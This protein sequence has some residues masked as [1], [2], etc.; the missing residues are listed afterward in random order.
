[1]SLRG[2]NTASAPGSC[3]GRFLCEQPD[4]V[5]NFK[6]DWQANRS[7]TE[8]Y[9]RM[10]TALRRKMSGA[11]KREREEWR[12]GDDSP[13]AGA[14]S[15]TSAVG[16]E[17]PRTKV[18][19]VQDAY[20]PASPISPTVAAG[21]FPRSTRH[22]APEAVSIKPPPTTEDPINST[23][24]GAGNVNATMD[25]AMALDAIKRRLEHTT[26]P[27][28]QAT[29]LLQLSSVAM[30]PGATTNAVIDFLFSFLQQHQQSGG[31]NPSAS[32]GNE[33][34]THATPASS[35][36]GT[37]P[38][39][40]GAIV[41]GL[42][43]LLAVKAKVVEPMIHV[44]DMAEQLVQCMS[45]AE[46]FKLRH[47]MLR[48]VVDCRMI[49]K[50]YDQLEL[51][52]RACVHHGDAGM[53]AICLRGYL[54]LHD[55]GYR[56]S[57]A[58]S[59]KLFDLLS[60]FLLHGNDDDHVRVVA[61]R[62]LAALSQVHPELLEV[63]SKYFP[64]SSSL[65]FR[66]KVFYVLCMSANDISAVVRKEIAICM[67]SFD[68]GNGGGGS[69]DAVV[70]HALQKAQISEE[71]TDTEMKSVQMLSSGAL[72][73]LLEDKSV[74]YSF[75]GFCRGLDVV[76]GCHGS[77]QEY[78]IPADEVR[79]EMERT[80]P[81]SRDRDARG[82]AAACLLTQRK[83]CYHEEFSLTSEEV[84]FIMSDEN[85]Q[86]DASAMA[87]IL[88]CL[89]LC[90]TSSVWMVQRIVEY[91]LHG[92]AHI[93]SDNE[94]EIERFIQVVE[95][96]QQ[97]CG[98]AIRMDVSLMDT[99]REAET[100]K[101][102]VVGSATVRVCA[103]L[104]NQQNASPSVQEDGGGSR[105]ITALFKLA[106]KETPRQRHSGSAAN[107]IE[108]S[109]YA[110]LQQCQPSSKTF[111]ANLKTVLVLYLFIQCLRSAAGVKSEASGL[112]ILE[113]VLQL[114]QHVWNA[115]PET[116]ST[117]PT[118]SYVSMDAMLGHSDGANRDDSKAPSDAYSRPHLS[119]PLTRGCQEL[120]DLASELYIKEQ[121][122]SVK[123]R[124]DL[125]QT[126]LLARGG[127][128][129]AH[130]QRHP[131]DVDEVS[132]H[133]RWLSSE[134][135]KLRF[136]FT[137]QHVM[138]EEWFSDQLNN[139]VTSLD[140]FKHLPSRCVS[141][142]IYEP[143]QDSKE[144]EIIAQWP[145]DVRIRG[146]LE[147]VSDL[148]QIYVKVQNSV[149]PYDRIGIDPC[150]LPNGETK[151]HHVPL[152]TIGFQTAAKYLVD[153][154]ISLTVPPFSDPTSFSISLCIQHPELPGATE[155]KQQPD[156]SKCATEA[157]V[158]PSFTEISEP[159]KSRIF[160]RT[161]ATIRPTTMRAS[162]TA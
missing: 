123:P 37:E 73:D 94:Q 126:I 121:G 15:I 47:D 107:G 2:L 66:E 141:A 30:S 44:D 21:I 63:P 134:A 35:G 150:V 49:S 91:V 103:A 10:G 115:F 6:D 124:A 146:K 57:T 112:R 40:L 83:A 48:I 60:T 140:A 98:G 8:D 80:R 28:L 159:V 85:A 158:S 61:V 18:T 92:A 144:R 16:A 26:E 135:V 23:A 128:V 22:Q 96:I 24:L 102:V 116:E 100:H 118:S 13:T 65:S 139:S 72:L 113:L 19:R 160:H 101:S 76:P 43:N 27:H 117:R 161:I 138:P 56:L 129:L 59:V 69:F 133:L 79:L 53:Q 81:G 84:N 89:L 88:S 14:L 147:N 50:K 3:N 97:K 1:M 12:A 55:A 155:M 82:P 68:A 17:G 153:H 157:V 109:W 122:W 111:T 78:R 58:S 62:L 70:E 86:T 156:G 137:D 71:L 110:D 148:T 20:I 162:A 90:E 105:S 136:L 5:I 114:K 4:G 143:S 9:P 45:V 106:P 74:E 38:T 127:L 32:P 152:S 67:R 142:V 33:S 108:A 36:G 29:L 95:S 11:M 42:R 93:N 145:F 41:R 125:L 52:L 39:V 154:R 51:L 77:D 99:I 75:D 151:Y 46:D 54:R 7:G 64:T 149:K 131:S 119:A 132:S 120:I 25:P 130:L 34:R 31:G 104:L 87:A